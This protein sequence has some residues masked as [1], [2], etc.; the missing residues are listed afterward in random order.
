MIP[1]IFVAALVGIS[2]LAA[3]TDLALRSTLMPSADLFYK[4]PENLDAVPPGTVLKIRKTPAPIAAFGIRSVN[5]RESY[6]ILYKTS[7]A[8][9]AS[10]ATVVTAL[11]P[12]NAHLDKILSYQMAEDSAS[13]NCAPSYALLQGSARLGKFSTPL[14]KAEFILVEAAL[15]Q[16]WIVISPDHEG[17]HAT[18]LGNVLAGR[19]TLDGIRAVINSADKTGISAKP[20]VAL[21]GYSGG[22]V[23]TAWAAELHGSYAPELNI[24]GAALGG[25][26]PNIANVVTSVD[27]TFATGLLAS[28]IMG[29]ANQ[30]PVA[31]DA[32]ENHVLPQFKSVFARAG[33]QCLAADLASFPFKRIADMFDKPG[34][35]QSKPILD[36]LGENALGKAVPRAPIFIYK[37]ILDEISPV[38]DTDDMVDFYCKNGGSVRYDRDL[39]SNHEISGVSGVGKAMVW[40]KQAMEGTL[41]QKGC[42]TT[43]VLTSLWDKSAITVLPKVGMNV[44]LDLLG[45]R[46]G[47]K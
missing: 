37:S 22:S 30:Y 3:P 44:L 40:L 26:V 15:H 36:M 18:F 29:L 8:S 47:G 19:A 38:K 43:S 14:T 4:A 13:P 9:N 39:L 2:A 31:R 34:F 21:W 12:H 35:L 32:V 42:T 6:Q 17:P 33:A 5:L 23:A 46:V 11:I 27:G 10:V 41:Q 1:R 45:K 24:V 7:D 28:G 25:T 20:T 16:G